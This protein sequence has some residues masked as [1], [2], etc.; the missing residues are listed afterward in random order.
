[1]TLTLGLPA[2]TGA[3]I[4]SMFR[5]GGDYYSKISDVIFDKLPELLPRRLRRMILN[6]VPWVVRVLEKLDAAEQLDERTTDA[7]IAGLAGVSVRVVQYVLWAL[8][9][10]MDQAGMAI[11]RRIHAHGRRIIS[12]IRGFAPSGSKGFS[13]PAPPI[14][15][16][17]TT[18]TRE[19]SSSFRSAPENAGEAR[20]VAPPE[21][22]DRACRLVPEATPGKVADAVGVYGADWVR[23]ALDRVEKRNA[24]RDN[25]PVKSW[26][27]VL[28]TLKNW[29][30]EGSAPP[31]PQPPAPPK[32]KP[33][34]QPAKEEESQQFTAKQL[35]ELVELCQSA[36][37]AICGFACKQLAVA[38]ADG[39]I[40]AELVATIPAELMEATKPR[41]P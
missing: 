19:T 20:E 10:L 17:E 11:I 4:A 1:V 34:E 36:S 32:P 27:F 18:T 28:N 30:R 41:A 9:V 5:Q 38:L 39:S 40:P 33:K 16:E 15:T 23:K 26:G 2:P 12:F 3:G 14:K 37:R 13:P 29:G 35:A 31:D 8:D 22:V 6:A 25:K 21:L 7:M 24:N